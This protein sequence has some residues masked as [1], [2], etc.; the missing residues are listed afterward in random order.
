VYVFKTI[1]PKLTRLIHKE[2]EDFLEPTNLMTNQNVLLLNET[3]TIIYIPILVIP[4]G[5]PNGPVKSP[6]DMAWSEI[7]KKQYV[8]NRAS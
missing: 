6:A 8:G 1:A 5:R 7:K 2:W 3:I 4:L